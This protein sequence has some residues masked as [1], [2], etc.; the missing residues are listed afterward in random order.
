MSDPIDLSSISSKKLI[1]EL[2]KRKDVVHYILSKE[3]VKELCD[4]Y[5]ISDAEG[6]FKALNTGG[7]IEI[8]SDWL[9]AR[10]DEY[11][12]DEDEDDDDSFAP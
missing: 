2:Y 6:I 10:R 8:V 1:E 5:E 12:E 9:D 11:N 3:S 4:D 7:M